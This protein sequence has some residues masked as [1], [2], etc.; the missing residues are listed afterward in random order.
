MPPLGSRRKSKR[1]FFRSTR[2]NVALSDTT[3]HLAIPV[4]KYNFMKPELFMFQSSPSLLGKD[5]NRTAI[6]ETCRDQ[7]ST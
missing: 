4:I 2:K 6:L 1:L 7:P 5:R 3:I